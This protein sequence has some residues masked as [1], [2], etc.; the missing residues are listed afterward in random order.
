VAS[1]MAQHA[2]VGRLT[3]PSVYHVRLFDLLFVPSYFWGP[4]VLAA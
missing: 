3:G 4:R 1:R 2:T